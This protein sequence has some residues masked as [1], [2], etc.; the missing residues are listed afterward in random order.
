MDVQ[1]RTGGRA[2]DAE[3]APH[4]DGWTTAQP[5]VPHVHSGDVGWHLRSGDEAVDGTVLTWDVDGAP[6]AAGLLDTGVLRTAFAPGW[7]GSRELAARMAEDCVSPGYV[8]ALSGTALRHHLL[9][10]GWS[11][12][13]DP[14]VV[15]HK[16]LGPADT[17][18]DDPDTRPVEGPADVAERVA[19]QRSAFAPGS[20]FTP[21]R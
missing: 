21:P 17:E 20:T 13:P 11:A 16:N 18:H 6:V 9:A 14:W 19:V 1:R 10:A 5:Y 15:L 2:L 4:L 12:D 3:L 8:D 7:S